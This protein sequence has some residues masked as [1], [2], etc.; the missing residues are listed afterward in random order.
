MLDAAAGHAA[1]PLYVAEVNVVFNS[2]GSLA[3]APR[4][5]NPPGDPAWTAH[6][7]SAVRAVLKCNPLRVPP[8]FAPYFE[9]WRSK[10]I[11]FDPTSEAG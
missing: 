5:V 3:G 4:L 8:E 1:G 11:H 6:A 7:E 9:Q 10:I 2:D